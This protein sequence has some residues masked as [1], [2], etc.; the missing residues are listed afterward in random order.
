MPLT[1]HVRQEGTIT[2]PAALRRRYAITA[3]TPYTVID[4]G[5]GALLLVPGVSEVAR[6]GE[7]VHQAMQAAGVSVEEMVQAISEA[8][9]GY[10]AENSTPPPDISG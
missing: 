4:L 6:W 7:K 10:H 2:L 8:R 3:G 9:E 1:V 5:D